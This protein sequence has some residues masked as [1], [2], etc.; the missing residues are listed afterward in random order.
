MNK[1]LPYTKINPSA[2][3]AG[4]NF[5]TMTNT[6]FDPMVKQRINEIENIVK[7]KNKK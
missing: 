7:N 5:V 2:N 4:F 1:G 6:I 3:I